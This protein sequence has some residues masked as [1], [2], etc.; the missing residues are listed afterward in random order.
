MYLVHYC[1]YFEF[2]EVR[3]HFELLKQFLCCLSFLAFQ[4]F[5][6]VTFI[7]SEEYLYRFISEVKRM[8]RVSEKMGNIPRQS[9]WFKVPQNVFT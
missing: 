7:L 6:G 4:V 1:G 3:F 5:T 2:Y 9:S 8:V